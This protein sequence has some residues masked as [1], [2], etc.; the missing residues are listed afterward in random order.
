MTRLCSIPRNRV[1]AV[2]WMVMA[3]A[4]GAS[5]EWKEKVLY[6]FQGL[7]NDGAYPAGGMVSDKAGNFYGA[8]GWGGGSV[9]ECPGIAQCGIVY[10]LKPP[11]E[12]GRPWAETVLYIFKG[13]NY[14]DGNTPQGGEIFDQAGNLYG[15]TAYGGNGPCQ[16]F[17]DRVGCGTVFELIPPKEKGGK[18][19]EKVLHS[20]QG[21]KDGYF[22]WGD[23]T[24]DSAGNLYGATQ[25]GGGYGS[26]NAPYYQYCGT[27]FKLSPPKAKGGKWTEQVLYA[28][29]S[30]TD[31]ANP[32]GGLIFDGKGALYGTTV[33][34]GNQACGSSSGVGCGTVFELQPPIKKGA[35]WTEKLLLRFR[36]DESM[37][38]EPAA[39]VIFG[40][41]GDLYGTTAGGG[42]HKPSEG[43]VFRLHNVSGDSWSETLLESFDGSEGGD[44]LAGLI[45]DLKGSLYGTANRGG[46]SAAGTVF[47]LARRGPE[48]KN[49]LYTVLY[50]FGSPADGGNPQSSLI[51]DRHGN[52]LGTTLYGGTGTG[53]EYG[54]CGTVFELQP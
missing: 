21:R 46:Q 50:S 6:S 32:N 36:S 10:Q 34:G 29:K 43:T 5:A 40:P 44:P 42:K 47:E 53:C 8:T 13:V 15:T 19:T 3:F 17:G 24:F 9:M 14:N 39:G 51:F 37:G 11:T 25:Y 35:A 27:V 28:F 48:Q 20:F 49:W 7:P 52:I 26:C 45:F 23:L 4:Q 30:G 22:P 38:D 12:K 16:L 41:D 1:F 2:L 31:G 33:Y 18:W 54:G